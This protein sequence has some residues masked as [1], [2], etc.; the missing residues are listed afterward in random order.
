METKIFVV[1]SKT[2]ACFHSLACVRASAPKKGRDEEAGIG[3]VL[4]RVKGG[5][6]PIDGGWGGWSSIK[7]HSRGGSQMERGC[8]DSRRIQTSPSLFLFLLFF[9]DDIFYSKG[10][11]SRVNKDIY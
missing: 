3:E 11:N 6:K 9:S 4:F 2:A 5:R 1:T 10:G 7:V 8:W